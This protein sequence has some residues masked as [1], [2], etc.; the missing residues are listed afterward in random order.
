MTKEITLYNS[1]RYDEKKADYEKFDDLYTGENKTLNSSIYL[2][3]H[4]LEADQTVD[5]A[6]QIRKTR[7]SL[8]RYT[9]FP[10]RAF[11]RYKSILFKEDPQ[12]DDE[13]MKFLESK[14]LYENIDGQGTNIISYIKDVIFKNKFIY[15]DTFLLTT[16]ED[17][18]PIWDVPNPMA[19]KEYGVKSGELNLFRYEYKV[20]EPRMRS[21]EKPEL[22]TYSDEY[23]IDGDTIYLARYKQIKSEE[24]DSKKLRWVLVSEEPITGF[25]ELPVTISLA[26]SF[27]D[28][29]SNDLLDYHNLKSALMNQLYHQAFDRIMVSGQVEEDQQF[30]LSAFTVTIIRQKNGEPNPT[31]TNIPAADVTAV[32]EQMFEASQNVLKAFFHYSRTITSDSGNIESAESQELAKDDLMNVIK[33]EIEDLERLI[34][35]GLHQLAIQAG[36]KD[37]KGKITFNKSIK[38]QDVEKE[39]REELAYYGVIQNRFNTWYKELLKKAVRR[40]NLEN[41]DQI[42]KE[43]DAYQGDATNTIDVNNV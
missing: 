43:I 6:R 36:V 39:L 16:S 9:N 30:A 4:E 3:Y 20:T 37:F 19:V 5:G 29:P 15:G 7:E 41:E 1:P 27:I 40:Q 21:S 28:E 35:K 10:K 12:I 2:P 18:N 38:I 31:V 14:D 13:A 11:R 22:I 17:D 24:K 33:S 23:Y 26:D 25:E 42:I 32:K 8:T 34:N